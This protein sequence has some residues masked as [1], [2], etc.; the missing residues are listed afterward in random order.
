M[1]IA[2]Q[3]LH[4]LYLKE[5]MDVVEE[6]LRKVDARLRSGQM[7]LVII[8][9]QG[10]HSS[11][12]AKIKPAVAEHLSKNGY[13]FEDDPAGGQF[14]VSFSN[15]PQASATTSVPQPAPATATAAPAPAAAA[16]AGGAA[17]QKESD[18]K[19]NAKLMAQLCSAATAVFWAVKSCFDKRSKDKA[20]EPQ[21]QS[22]SVPSSEPTEGAAAPTPAAAHVARV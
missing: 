14:T 17:P 7:D 11:G 20:E 13:P 4:G 9:G 21:T 6:R 2:S 1:T 15:A 10:I 16:P 12:A 8:V 5:A 19:S 3:D 18:A 22:R